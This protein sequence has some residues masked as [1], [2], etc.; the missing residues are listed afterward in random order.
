MGKNKG[1]HRWVQKE[2]AYAPAATCEKWCILFVDE[3][4]HGQ[5]RE[6]GF[7]LLATELHDWFISSSGC[8]DA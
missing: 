1:S 3:S 6:L 5:L 2:V 4:Q 8:D 7:N